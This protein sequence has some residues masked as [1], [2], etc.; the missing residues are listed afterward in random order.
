MSPS[1]ENS[2]RE[3][4]WWGS[5]VQML[6][7]RARKLREKEVIG[8]LFV[9]ID[10]AVW[11]NDSLF[12][13]MMK[14]PR[15]SPCILIAPEM[16]LKDPEERKR[17]MQSLIDYCNLRGFPHFTLCDES[18]N[19]QG[20]RIPEEYDILI[21]SKPY[22]GIV[23]S[24]LDYP[25]YPDRLLIRIPYGL[26]AS[27]QLSFFKLSYPM[28]SWMD[29]FENKPLLK[30][31]RKLKEHNRFNGVVTGLPVV[32]KL[33][34]PREK[35]PWKPQ[36]AETK[37]IIW[38]PHWTISTAVTMAC[39]QSNFE[40]LAM[41]MLEFAKQTLGRIQWAFKP[42]PLLKCTLYDHPD[43][44]KEK[45]D[46]Y[47]ALWANGSNTQVETGEYYD[48][49]KYSDGMVH[50]CDSFTVEYQ[51]TGKP[52][53]FITEDI[54]KHLSTRNIQG[55]TALKAH[56]IGTNME[57]IKAFVDEKILHANDPKKTERMKFLDEYLR[58]PHHK[59]A[60]ENIIQSI[61]GSSSK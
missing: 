7:E 5:Y 31:D 3:R 50:D 52:V 22:E 1:L 54:D 60:A 26:R 46:K 15:F 27:A 29:C 44:G 13:A 28:L 18:G 47:F 49:F 14:H 16:Q 58:P 43:W 57:D 12:D 2:Y 24:S 30:L 40:R 37:R 25:Q 61:L 41:P 35:N 20:Q 4:G 42:H 32:D 21:Y 17:Y 55:A 51:T 11:K 36:Q 10:L 39:S 38:A 19:T 53:M 59:T 23:P 34:S 45:T 33:L 48:L 56:Y 9:C 8:V 6:S